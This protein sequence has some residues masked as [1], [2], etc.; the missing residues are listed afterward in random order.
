MP[1]NQGERKLGGRT[2]EQQ[3]SENYRAVVVN[4]EDYKRTRQ[5]VTGEIA[6]A[7][8][9]PY[10]HVTKTS[11]E[12]GTEEVPERILDPKILR[13]PSRLLIPIMEDY[14]TDPNFPN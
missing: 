5:G 2:V 7:E 14:R 4:L 11:D 13:F 6:D 12:G 9:I 10:K 8:Y 3:D 1:E